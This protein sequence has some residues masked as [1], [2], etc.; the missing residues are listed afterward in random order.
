MQTLVGRP[1]EERLLGN[2]VREG[3]ICREIQI[4]GS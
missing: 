3:E 2:I 4:A 1:E